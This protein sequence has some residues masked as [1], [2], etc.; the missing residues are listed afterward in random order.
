MVANNSDRLIRGGAEIFLEASGLVLL[1]LEDDEEE[2]PMTDVDRSSGGSGV[3]VIKRLTGP[4]EGGKMGTSPKAAFE[5]FE[6]F[7]LLIESK[8]MADSVVKLTERME[9]IEA[10]QSLTLKKCT[11]VSEAAVQVAQKLKER[12]AD[13][14]KWMEEMERRFEELKRGSHGGEG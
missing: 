7:E 14:K 8:T 5:A 13:Q 10:A 11:Q 12:E 6:A 3:D 4:K 1:L 2:C 9:K